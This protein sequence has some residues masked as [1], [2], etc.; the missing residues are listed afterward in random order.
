MMQLLRSKLDYGHA[1]TMGMGRV[2]AVILDLIARQEANVKQR[3]S[4]TLNV[5]L[6]VNGREVIGQIINVPEQYLKSVADKINET[7]TP[8]AARSQNYQFVD[9]KSEDITY[10]PFNRSTFEVMSLA[11]QRHGMTPAT[12][13]RI[14]QQ[15]YEGDS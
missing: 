13:M 7:G 3:K 14:L 1:G 12:T 2:K 15:L 4:S 11:W 10:E 8:I 9:V 6:T 5:K